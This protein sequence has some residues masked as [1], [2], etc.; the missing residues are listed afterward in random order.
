MIR[1]IAIVAC[2][3][4]LSA[5]APLPDWVVAP[6]FLRPDAAPAPAAGHYNFD[7]QLS[8]ERRLA[9]IQVFDNGERT[10]LQFMPGQIIPAIFGR[11]QHGD[12]LLSH[13]RHGD[14]L[15]IDGVWPELSFRG[16]A[17]RATAQKQG[18][19]DSGDNSIDEP[20]GLGL[21][22]MSIGESLAAHGSV[23]VHG[24]RLFAADDSAGSLPETVSVPDSGDAMHAGPPTVAMAPPELSD[25][26]LRMTRASF[27]SI[28]PSYGVYGITLRD[29][30]LRRAL[31]RWAGQAS[32]TFA[33]EHWAVDVDIP[34]S[35]E[36]LFDGSF[37][38]AV[39]DLL[40]ATELAERPLRP[41]FYSNRVLRVVSYSQT[42]D[43]SNGARES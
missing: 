34:V 43:R 28:E 42:C 37:E 36:A 9:P 25:Q 23:D 30:N 13:T 33:P 17:S 15:V 21:E 2:V 24:D 16:G 20:A 19:F 3:A 27:E 32:W 29:Q 4:G 10:W 38:Q 41:C 11:T 5:C 35:G 39:Q 22:D 8:G 6:D 40:S 26:V 12:Q 7:W 18:G 31:Q 14:Y 1:I